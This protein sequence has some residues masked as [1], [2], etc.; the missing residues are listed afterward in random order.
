MKKML[1]VILLACFVT[2]FS[3]SASA[4]VKLSIGPKVGL[5]FGTISYDPDV[6]NKS[7]RTAAMFGA[8]VEILFANMFGI[9]IEPNYA[10]KGNKFEGQAT[11]T[12]QNGVPIG[13][14]TISVTRAVNEIQIPILFKAKFL[15]GPVRPY[16][17]LGPN[18]GIVSS[19]K[20]NFTISNIPQGVQLQQTSGETDQ[21]A[22]TSSLDFG[23]DIGGG[24]EFSLGGKVGLTADIRYSLGFSNLLKNPAGNASAKS[25]GFQIQFGAL[26]GI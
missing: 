20:D 21:S 8:Q 13:N 14:A 22:S 26:F 24:A 11:I 12:D 4:Q 17:L 16:T 15:Q 9:Q 7:G 2:G 1:A 18:I 19:A 10:M 25:R 3:A 23:F 6:T 5:N